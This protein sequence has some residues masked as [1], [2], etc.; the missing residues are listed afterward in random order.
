MSDITSFEGEYDFLSNFF[1]VPV[2]Y[3]YLLFGNSE[4][5]YQ[6]Q[7]STDDDEV[8]EFTKY[9]AGKAKRMGR[10]VELRDDWEE[11]KVEVMRDVVFA[12]FFQNPEL[13]ERL[14]A[15]GDSNL[16][17]GNN[18]HDT[19][20]GVDSE[21][22]E[23]QNMLGK[24]L[25]E[26][27]AEL[28]NPEIKLEDNKNFWITR[29]AAPE[30]VYFDWVPT[31]KTF[32]WNL[33]GSKEIRLSFERFYKIRRNEDDEDEHMGIEDCVWYFHDRVFCDLDFLL[34]KEVKT[35][36]ADRNSIQKI[37]AYDDGKKFFYQ[38]EK[39]PTFDEFD[40]EWDS[41][42]EFVIFRDERGISLLQG[43]HGWKI[44][45]ILI[46]TGLKNS[47]PQLEKILKLLD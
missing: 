5:A 36:Y 32:C 22:G 4:A 33:P 3:G 31:R 14:L 20:W 39:I 29:L 24:I 1:N 17:E 25:M 40:S 11:V 18:W 45:E 47:E 15:T 9:N 43:K 8:F 46:F 21:T 38:A 23:G 34:G 6:A 42:N 30:V 16:I 35:L 28:K 12:K 19:F 27:R 44:P 41:V 7:K 2:K 26:I 10:K 37:K 13:A